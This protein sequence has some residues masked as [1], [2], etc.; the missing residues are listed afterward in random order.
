MSDKPN[1]K[2]TPIKMEMALD[3]YISGMPMFIKKA[4]YDAGLLKAKYDALVGKGFKPE[5]ALEIIKARP[6]FE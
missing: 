4:A 5:E 6:L 3:N 2:I 1:G